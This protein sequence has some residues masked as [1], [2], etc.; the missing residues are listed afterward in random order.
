MLQTCNT[1]R[2][3]LRIKQQIFIPIYCFLTKKHGQKTQQQLGEIYPLVFIVTLQYLNSILSL[4]FKY[5]KK[6]SYKFLNNMKIIST[7]VLNNIKW[8]LFNSYNLFQ[9]N[10]KLSQLL[11]LHYFKTLEALLDISEL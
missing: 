8:P 3:K 7:N 2:L 6:I 9:I 11:F 10:K 4:Q 5:V 1:K